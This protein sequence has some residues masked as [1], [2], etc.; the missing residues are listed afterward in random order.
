MNIWLLK[1]FTFL[2]LVNYILDNMTGNVFHLSF[3]VHIILKH[4]HYQ[5]ATSSKFSHSMPEL[6]VFT[7]SIR[8]PQLLTIYILKLL[9]FIYIPLLTLSVQCKQNAPSEDSDQTA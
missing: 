1:K 8:T 7:L 4:N 6:T 9:E 2:P 3:K 5:C